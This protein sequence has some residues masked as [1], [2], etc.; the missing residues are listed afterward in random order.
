[1]NILIVEDQFIIAM[2]LKIKVEGLGYNV[3]GIESSAE[4]AIEKIPELLPDLILMDI[5]LKGDM[6]GIDATY[7]IWER[8]KIP[9]LYITAHSDELTLE[10]VKNSPGYGILIKPVSSQ[11][12]KTSIEMSYYQKTSKICHSKINSSIIPES[13]KSLLFHY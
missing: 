8:F 3:S 11:D 7:V 13:N 2:H 10:R 5:R 4:T 6:D 1:M 9:V 12:L